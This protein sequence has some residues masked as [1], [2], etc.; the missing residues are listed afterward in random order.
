MDRFFSK[1]VNRSVQKKTQIDFK[2]SFYKP[3][4]DCLCDDSVD[5][6]L[7]ELVAVKSNLYHL[8]SYWSMGKAVRFVKQIYP[9]DVS[10]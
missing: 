3:E 9:F 2:R 7:L 6:E 8:A 10:K 5:L 1:N 4:N